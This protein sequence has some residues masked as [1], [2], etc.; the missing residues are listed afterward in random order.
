MDRSS[1]R[2][3]RDL[4]VKWLVRT[5]FTDD[6]LHLGVTTALAEGGWA[7]VRKSPRV[8]ITAPV[9]LRGPLG[10]IAGTVHDLSVGGLF[11]AVAEPLEVETRLSLDLA[12]GDRTLALSGSVVHLSRRL[13][14]RREVGFGVCFDPVGEEDAR[15]LRE[16]V[17]ARM[18]SV[19]L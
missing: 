6:E 16:F 15:T 8:P 11:L 4:G 12:I 1:L 14:P 10:C 3:L 19:R 5:P 18:G 9:K 13:S 17:D 7:D 2:Q